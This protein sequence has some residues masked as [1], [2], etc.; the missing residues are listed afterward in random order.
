[1]ALMDPIRVDGL[2]QFRKALK[3]AESATPAMLR[4][5]L[6][7][8]AQIVVNVAK[9]RIPRRTGK[10]AATLKAASTGTKAQVKVGGNRAPY[11]PWLDFGG[12]VGRDDSVKRPII[13]GGRY[14]YPAVDQEYDNIVRRLEKGLADLAR[15]AGMDV[16]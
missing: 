16:S 3:D 13:K 14:V 1:M 15:D 5:V 9:P 7:D 11:Y 12:S 2:N 4:L 6:N 8:A 10:A